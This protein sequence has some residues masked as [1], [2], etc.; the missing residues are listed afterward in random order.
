MRP[1]TL[2]VLAALLGFLIL[3]ACGLG[4][5]SQELED[6]NATAGQAL[7]DDWAYAGPEPMMEDGSA[8]KGRP[9][10]TAPP[11]SGGAIAPSVMAAPM[12]MQS[13]ALGFS[14]GGAKDVGNFRENIEAGYL[15]LPT[16]LTYEGLFYDYYFDTAQEE[17]CRAL[18]CPSYSP[19]V[20]PDP[21]SGRMDY[22]LSVGLNSN[23][24][25]ADFARKKLNLVVVLDISGSMGSPFDEYY[26]DNPAKHDGE[27]DPDAGKTKMELAAKAVTLLMNHLGPGD[28]F[29]VVLFDDRAY[30]GKPLSP[31]ERT[32][33]AAIK[34]H[35]LAVTEQGGT[36][37]EAGMALGGTLLDEYVSADKAVYENRIIFLTDAMPNLGDTSEEGLLGMMRRN[38]DRGVYTTFIGIGVDLNTELVEAVTKVSGANS[39]SVHSAAEFKTRMDDEFEFMVTPLVFDL[40]LEVEAEGFEIERVYGSPQADQATGEIM[41]V[42][43]LFPSRT[44]EG[45]TR[46]GVVLLK[47]RKTGDNAAVTLRTSYK[48]RDHVPGTATTAIALARQDEFYGG[49]GVR[50]AVALVR[51]ADL[52]LN[53][54]E[55]ERAKGQAP[56]PDETYMRDGIP[57]PPL[58]ELGQWERTSMDLAVAREYRMIFSLFRG[59]LDKEMRAVDDGSMERELDLLDRL[60]EHGS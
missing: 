6:Q 31:V 57:L 34:G 22:Y 1:R 53:W 11:M 3:A 37:M 27:T 5:E 54:M 7:V 8:Y 46:G 38:A 18:F 19:A 52:M 14:A 23:L 10:G 43:T 45:R 51:Y 50:K 41:R 33:M 56:P 13:E 55:F 35:V 2:S 59:Y 28:R 36:N 44:E 40:V 15:P 39:Y 30:L 60:I 4:E 48:D 12:A 17:P 49:T 24:T 9:K 58:P 47:L 29:G 42:P 20:S 21:F 32:D 25:E 26:Y 16:D